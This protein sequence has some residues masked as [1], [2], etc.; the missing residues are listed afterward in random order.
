MTTLILVIGISIGISFLCSVLEAVLLSISHSYVGILKEEGHPAGRLLEDMRKNID[1]PIAAILTLN[2]IAHTVGATMGGAIAL[3]VFGD[4]WIALFSAALTLAILIF[5]EIVPKTLGATW[6]QSLAPLAARVLRWMILLMKPVLIP[7][8][9]F[10]RLITPRG[11]ERATV[12][13]AELEVLAEIGR[14][15]G[16]I[17]QAE[18]TVMRNIMNLD[19]VTVGQVMTPRT[20]MV[21]IPSEASLEEAQR[22]MME[23]G[24][25][26]LPVYDGG[27]DKIVGIL[28]ARDL[29]KAQAQ[30]TAALAEVTRAPTFVPESKPVEEQIAAMRQQRIKMA[31]VLDEYGGTAGLV[32]LED[33]IEEI[34][35]EIHDEHELEP[36]PFEDRPAGEVRIAG[37]ATLGDVNERLGLS[38]PEDDYETLGGYLF[39][40]LGRVGEEGDEVEVR[41]GRFRVIAM[42]ARRIARVAFSPGSDPDADPDGRSYADPDD[43]E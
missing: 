9:W 38:L 10:N 16:A 21:A 13:R 31:I 4:R 27:L 42:D 14:R 25:L 40:A 30:G 32:T 36:L 35:G 41:G 18:W 6:W 22:V 1:E 26:R 24:H 17:D 12:S 28:L 2:T 34:V 43:S 19:T 37:S 5:S 33:M 11:K 15:E 7:L 39:G 23:K 3:E 8:A 20:R 29:W